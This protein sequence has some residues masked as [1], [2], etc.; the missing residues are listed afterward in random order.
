MRPL[1]Y[2]ATT[3]KLIVAFASIFDEMQI[4]TEG[5]VVK[6]PL[7]FSQ[8]EK[9]IDHLAG[10]VDVDMDDINY[11]IVFP[12]MGF[13][14]TGFN[15]SAERHLNPLHTWVEDLTDGSSVEMYNRVPYDVSFSLYIGAKKLEDSLKIVEQIWPYFKPEL[16][17]TINDR[18]E[19]K[20]ETNIP[21]TL[22]SS[23]MTIDYEGSLDQR[24]T[25][26]WQLDFTAKAFYYAVATE[27]TR[28]KQTV[29]NMRS[30]D[31]DSKYE[32]LMSTVTP[33][34]ANKGDIHTIV[35]QVIQNG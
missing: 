20:T 5:R 14:V 17:L 34:S 15:F 7:L 32:T 25:I 12:C 6:V 8:K 1:G 28:I 35:D 9:F 31:F 11:D 33:M 24:R 19:F 3:K 26:M 18:E 27:S 21:F 30:I 13:E 2:Y 16:T 4:E 23:S 29:M 22:N 10:G